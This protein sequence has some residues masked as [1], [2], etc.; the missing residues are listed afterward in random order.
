M[1]QI[2]GKRHVALEFEARKLIN[3]VNILFGHKF[4]EKIFEPF[5][6]FG[7]CSNRF[8]ILSTYRMDNKETKGSK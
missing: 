5:S 8:E 3:H 4:R 1:D 7:I 6:T 2:C